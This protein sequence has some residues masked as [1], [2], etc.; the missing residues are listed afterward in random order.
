LQLGILIEQMRREGFEIVISPPRILTYQD[1]D[2]QLFEPFEEVTVDVDA[3]YSGTVVSALTGDR[4][5]I[6]ME[7][8]N[9]GQGD[10]GD[11]N[12]GKSRLIFE[13]PSRGLLGFHSE[14]ATLTKGS[15]VVN[16]VFLEDRPHVGSLHGM[17]KSKLV[18]SAQ[19]KATAHALASLAARGTLFI[20][21]GDMVYSGMVIGENSKTNSP[22][23]EVNPVRAKEVTNMRTVNKDEKIHLPPAKK[24][25]VEELI[26]YMNEDEV[27]EV[28][29]HHIRLRK[30]LLD[31]SA[32]ER[33]SRNKAKQLRS[34]K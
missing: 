31:A 17:T 10:K 16:H 24:M 1:E 15:A 8:I 4:K 12:D 9:S 23:L 7:M 13:V 22:D 2:G 6:L 30:A 11:S 5:G 18:S 33:A 32:R 28:T 29:P 34:A 21:P 19:G 20:E 26:G 27:L 25:S 14:I 3:E